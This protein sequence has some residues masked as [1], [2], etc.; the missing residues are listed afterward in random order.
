MKLIIDALKAGNKIMICGNGGSASDAA[1]FTAELVG[2]FVKERKPLPCIDLTSS[3]A[4]ITAIAN[5]YGYDQVFA[6]QV[7]AH[8]KRG[9]VLI[10]LTT[11]GNSENCIQ[12]M[13]VAQPLG[14]KCVIISGPKNSKIDDEMT[15]NDKFILADGST[16]AEI[17]EETIKV[18]HS[19]CE[20]IDENF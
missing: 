10:V 19:I 8:G 20:A 12:A 17:Q 7:Q 16:T 3:N 14:V 9:D 13:R 11:S 1:H 18:L 5:D 4:T 2:R 6:R 15:G